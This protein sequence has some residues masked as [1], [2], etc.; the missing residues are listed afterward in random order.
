MMDVESFSPLAGIRG[1]QPPP[2]SCTALSTATAWFQSPRG[3]SRVATSTTSRPPASTG[4]GFSPLA[5]IRGLQ[6]SPAPRLRVAVELFQSPR[7]DSRVATAR[8]RLYEGPQGSAVSV[9]SRGF[10][11]CN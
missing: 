11:G 4:C 6:P 10:E 9:P 5:G 7:G 1:L 2:A 3:D 8:G